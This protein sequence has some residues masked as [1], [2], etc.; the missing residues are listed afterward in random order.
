MH[1][2][3]LLSSSLTYKKAVENAKIRGSLQDTAVQAQN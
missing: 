1:D 3:I 2:A